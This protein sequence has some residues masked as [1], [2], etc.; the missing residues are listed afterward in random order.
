MTTPIPPTP[1]VVE[2][3]T[4]I[5]DAVTVSPEATDASA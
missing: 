5:G 1:T 3:L 4:I 2:S